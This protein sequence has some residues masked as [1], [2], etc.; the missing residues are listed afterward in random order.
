MDY[1]KKNLT[2][3]FNYE[4]ELKDKIGDGGNAKVFKCKNK[5]DNAEYAVKI[6]DRTVLFD[7]GIKINQKDV[8]QEM[9]HE[10]RLLSS[11]KHENII[12]FYESFESFNY[13]HMIMEYLPGKDLYDYIQD[14][15]KSTIKF[16]GISSGLPEI[17][18]RMMFHHIL[19]G[20]HYLHDKNI[21]HRD[22]KAEN[23]WISNPIQSLST[24]FSLPKVK[25][26]DF[27]LARRLDEYGG[28]LYDYAGSEY[29]V[30][31]EVMR[32][33]RNDKYQVN[34]NSDS[35]GTK[36]DCWSA[37]ILLYAM[38]FARYPS[39]GEDDQYYF[40]HCTDGIAENTTI[41]NSLKNLLY[42]L[43]E[44]D[45][46]VRLSTDQALKH[47]WFDPILSIAF[48]SSEDV[49]HNNNKYYS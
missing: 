38:I 16:S 21:V 24:S 39:K 15:S 6:F 31:P 10:V 28:K 37:G 47:E 11:L 1:L 7:G 43:L 48:D 41:S 23:V 49:I 33:K 35:Y 25:L 12:K 3:D 29:Y 17:E 13:L 22:I 46:K 34:Y 9:R 20:L 32:C 18:A 36:V 5:S 40:T 26:L 42:S 14:V 44:L 30:A 45:P 27:G 2:H 19:R 4:Y 8:V